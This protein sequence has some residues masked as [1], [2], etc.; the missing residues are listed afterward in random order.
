[1][2]I[3]AILEWTNISP[4]NFTLKFWSSLYGGQKLTYSEVWLHGALKSRGENGL[5]FII[6]LVLLRL[7]YEESCKYD[8]KNFFG[9]N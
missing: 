7:W 8:H 2:K 6:E 3:W 5:A 9:S 1:M 4:D